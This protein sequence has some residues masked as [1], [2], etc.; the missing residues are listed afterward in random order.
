MRNLAIE[1]D[2]ACDIE[3]DSSDSEMLAGSVVLTTDWAVDF[4]V[5]FE[6]DQEERR[7][8]E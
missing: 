4:A 1:V 2:L 5:D 7:G 3:S 6:V 8:E